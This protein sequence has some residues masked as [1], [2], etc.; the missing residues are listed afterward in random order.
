MS[1]DLM[2][3]IYDYSDKYYLYDSSAVNHNKLVADSKP[4]CRFRANTVG[5]WSL[6]RI[7]S[8]SITAKKILSC[9]IET[10]DN[11]SKVTPDMFVKN[12]NSGTLY[13]IA[14]IPE[15]DDDA[16]QETFR[17]SPATIRKIMIVGFGET[18][19]LINL[20]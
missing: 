18:T 10:R 3:G 14:E 19:W 16:D 17:K 9:I 7:S 1:R 11:L 6:R 5:G 13:K 2:Y 15:F 20:Y 12:I 8:G 4:L